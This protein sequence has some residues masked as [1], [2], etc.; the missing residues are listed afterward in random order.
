MRYFIELSYKGTAF[1]GWQIQE[2]ADS[3]QSQLNNALSTLL[4]EPIETTGCGRTDSGVHASQFFAHFDADT[5]IHDAK[6]LVYRLNAILPREICV[7]EIL[8]MEADAHARFDAIFRSYCYYISREKNPFLQDYC[9]IFTQ[10]LD[11]SLMNEA[12]ALFINHSDYAS[13]AK[14]GGQQHTT[15][16]TVTEAFFTEKNGILCY[17]VSANRFLRGMVRTMV[18]TLLNL[19]EKKININQFKAILESGNRSNAGQSVPAQG[20]FLEEI[21]YPY[22]HS[23][24]RKPFEL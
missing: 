8:K 24:R 6:D 9:W 10:D 7:Y 22:L 3:V 2:N 11:L 23:R 5:V 18:G 14:A 16:C 20:L 1:H 17:Q 12:A 15:L 13:F 19:G 21:R 4:R